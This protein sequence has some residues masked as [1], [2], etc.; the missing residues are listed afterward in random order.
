MNHGRNLKGL[1]LFGQNETSCTDKDLQFMV[2]F[3]LQQRTISIE[4]VDAL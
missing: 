3:L 2:K 4:F 1:S